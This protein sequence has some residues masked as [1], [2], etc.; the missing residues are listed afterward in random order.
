MINK[1]LE[2]DTINPIDI[3]VYH[4]VM[5]NKINEIIDYLNSNNFGVNRPHKLYAVEN[6][7]TKGII[8]SARGGAYQ[9]KS[10]AE[11]K[12]KL[13]QQENPR[14]HYRIIEYELKI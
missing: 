6:E 12:T 2:T 4:N 3:R 7:T 14:F 11:D 13:L 1:I 8:F 9:N 5:I 10:A